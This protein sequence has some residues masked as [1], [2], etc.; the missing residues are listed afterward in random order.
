LAAL[1]DNLGRFDQLPEG[2]RSQVL[3]FLD[4]AAGL[5]NSASPDD[6]QAVLKASGDYFPKYVFSTRA[7]ELADWARGSAAYLRQSG[8]FA[9]IPALLDCAEADDPFLRQQVAHALTFWDGTPA[10]DQR[11]EAALLR[12]ARDDGHGTA[13]EVGEGD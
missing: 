3:E 11:I 10:E 6:I 13:I 9:V 8:P 12:L 7:G 5:S 2:R 1:G 4:Q